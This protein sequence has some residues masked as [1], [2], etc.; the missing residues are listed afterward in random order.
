MAAALAGKGA[1]F[2]ANV[3]DRLKPEVLMRSGVQRRPVSTARRGPAAP[4]AANLYLL[5]VTVPDD[6]YMAVANMPP[7][8]EQDR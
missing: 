4:V 3:I 1:P 5:L 7:L 2:T 8:G 6:A